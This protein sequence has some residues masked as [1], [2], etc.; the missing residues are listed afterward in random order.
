MN[1]EQLSKS[2]IVLLTLLVSFI[3]SI[4]T[5]IVTVSLMEQAPPIIAQ[6]VN[7]VIEKTV[8]K[9][10]PSGQAA[11]TAITQEKTIVVR[12]SDLISQALDKVS[13]SVVRLYS[14]DAANPQFLGLGFVLD[15]TG[16][17]VADGASIGESAEAQVSAANGMNVRGFVSNRDP[18]SGLVLLKTATTTDDGKPATWS[19]ATI[20]VTHQVLGATVVMLSGKS[21]TRIQDGIVTAL[22]PVDT[23]DTPP[24]IDTSIDQSMIMYGSPLINTDGDIVGVSSSVSRASSPSGFISATTVIKQ[25]SATKETP[26]ATQ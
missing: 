10:V 1:I 21:S 3:T 5:G 6:S 18:S 9:V 12:E 17:I 22:S 4:A 25:A 19:P 24:I 16:T 7:R 23:S 14:L 20:A 11:S 26:P 15:Q 8:E 2:Q 13:P